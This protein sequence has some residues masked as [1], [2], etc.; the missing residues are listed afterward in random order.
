MA[1]S[2]V[3][4]SVRPDLVSLFVQGISD[5]SLAV[6]DIR[7]QESDVTRLGSC[8]ARCDQGAGGGAV[9]VSSGLSGMILVTIV[10]TRDK[11]ADTM[12]DDNYTPHC[13]TQMNSICWSITQP[14]HAINFQSWRLVY[15]RTQY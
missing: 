11:Y 9:G 10:M 14:Q 5:K 15:S 1:A 13:F 4:V 7:A 12:A 3:S 2:V 8:D 6:R